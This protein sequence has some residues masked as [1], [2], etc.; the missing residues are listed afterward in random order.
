MHI[1]YCYIS[2]N[3]LNTSI[4][5]AFIFRPC[6]HL[7]LVKGEQPGRASLPLQGCLNVAVTSNKN[8]KNRLN[9]K[10]RRR[11][12]TRIKMTLVLMSL[13]V[14]MRTVGWVSQVLLRLVFLGLLSP[15]QGTTTIFHVLLLV[16]F[17]E[18]QLPGNHQRF[19]ELAEACR[20]S[21]STV[22]DQ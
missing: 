13:P 5:I 4:V 10:K 3:L 21:G 20:V 22:Q 14:T 15:H 16:Q 11:T 2:I 17:Q 8:N 6:L 19:Q 9:Q 7:L 1:A 18:R 12:T